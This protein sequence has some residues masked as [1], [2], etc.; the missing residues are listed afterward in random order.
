[1]LIRTC[2][3]PILLYVAQF[4]GAAA[5]DVTHTSLR[6]T[7]GAIL[8]DG[9]PYFPFGLY[10][11]SNSISVETAMSYLRDMANGGLNC[12][13]MK[14]T[15][16][17]GRVLD[18]ADRLGLKI[19]VESRYGSILSGTTISDF[20]N[21]P[22]VIA[23]NFSDDA[24][25][26]TTTTDELRRRYDAVKA[27]DP[28]RLAFFSLTGYY[29]NRRSRAAEFLNLTDSA[30]FQSYPIS[31]LP[32]FEVQPDI[33]LSDH[34]LRCRQYVDAAASLTPK[35][36]LLVT[37]Q[38]FSWDL[39]SPG[40]HRMPTPAEE[41]NM[42]YAAYAAGAKGIVGY[43]YL[44]LPDEANLWNEVKALARET[45]VLA[46]VLLDGAINRVDTG[47]EN[48]VASTWRT[49][50]QV[51]VVVIN[52]SYSLTKSASITL[53]DGARNL[54]SLFTGRPSGLALNG[55]RLI[56]SVAPLDVHVYRVDLSAA[57]QAPT[58]SLATPTGTFTAPATVTL[59]AT[60][61]D[62][63]GSIAKVEFFIGTTLLS[64]DTTS[65]YVATW[66]TSA[67]GSYEVT[68][69]ATDNLGATTVSP[70]Q[71]V[72]ISTAGAGNG[73]TGIYFT[74]RNLANA[75]V[76]RTDSTVDF[77][78]GTGAPAS[79]IGADNFSA[80]WTG[81]VQAQFSETYTFTTLSDDGIRLWVNGQQLIN[82]W[83]DHAPIENSGT[84]T[85]LAGQKY[86]VKMEFYEN[87]GGAVAK[88]S[89]A[90]PS[91]A[92][93][94]I[95]STQL[96]PS[97]PGALPA[98]W[99]AQDIGGVALSGSTTLN[100]GTWTI[101][102]SGADIWENADGFQFASQRV[103]GDV[104]VT[105]KVTSLTNTNDWAKAGVMI[106]ES[107]SAGS[108][109]ASTFATAAN[110]L[111][112]QRR[113]DTNGYSSHTAG[114]GNPAPYWVRIER[115]SNV[116][117]SSTSPN[118]TTWTEIRRETITMSAAIYVGVAVTSHNNG[119][120]CTGTFTN[121]QVVG[122]AAASN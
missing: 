122:V 107:L 81:Q 111:A 9:V 49:T 50:D 89:W 90:S 113:L 33:A 75:A 22:A 78:W 73:L 26:G 2:L 8:V 64:T 84:I 92:K 6:A 13:H 82:N 106:R 80:R 96:F 16:D 40:S 34:Y 97:I 57:N 4:A 112:Y 63:D 30:G 67:A 93:Q 55:L 54:T 85:L 101:S 1:M 120:L 104:Q 14:E 19:I 117:I 7:D 5:A 66:T 118:G 18:E 79:G 98:G 109:H 25:N 45:T 35:R 119:A 39:V 46:P 91:T 23:W 60:A 70:S 20:R 43:T 10:E 37:T 53:P 61:N 86:D 29:A 94:I 52:T 38:T 68:A 56:G 24:D 69:Q 3:I 103:T 87:G 51:T 44:G 72:V 28:T 108:R 41:R 36:N 42:T 114:P 105:A 58:V 11:E 27:A 17:F 83:T 76:T 65:P 121:V 48:L 12:V 62:S 102:G 77:D 47:D 95:P 88:L 100:N 110:G 31:P 71:T 116:V 59:S 74:D 15:P 115:M 99:T 32:D 21:K